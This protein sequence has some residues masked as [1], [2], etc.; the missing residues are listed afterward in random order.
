MRVGRTERGGARART[1]ASAPARAQ[2][3][4]T[5]TAAPAAPAAAA[6]ATDTAEQARGGTAGARK[7]RLEL[8]QIGTDLFAEYIAQ[9]MLFLY[10]PDNRSAETDKTY[11]E[12]AH[13]AAIA[14]VR[15]F[16]SR[17]AEIVSRETN[18]SVAA[19]T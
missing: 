6:P 19:L 15:S 9:V 10:S 14:R 4:A 13:G 16:V 1:G 11:E 7:P 8:G 12:Q 2:A 18:A 3:K 5:A 17:D